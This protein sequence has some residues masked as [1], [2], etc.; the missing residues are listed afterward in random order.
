MGGVAQADL[1]GQDTLTSDREFVHNLLH[2]LPD[3]FNG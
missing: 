2:A 3:G 1:H